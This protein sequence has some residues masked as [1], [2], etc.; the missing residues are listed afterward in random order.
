MAK[1][2]SP[3]VSSH[4][5]RTAA[6]KSV[7]SSCGTTSAGTGGSGGVDLPNIGGAYYGQPPPPVLRLS[8]AV[9]VKAQL[10]G[11][12]TVRSSDALLANVLA[13]K[14]TVSCVAEVT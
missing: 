12:V 11:L 6:A 14:C 8:A 1:L 9:S 10:S 13:A 4:S 3:L 7:A 5:R 2:P